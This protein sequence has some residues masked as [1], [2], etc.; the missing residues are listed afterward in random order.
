MVASNGKERVV[1]AADLLF[2]GVRHRRGIRRIAGEGAR[3]VQHRRSA[4]AI[5][6]QSHPWRPLRDGGSAADVILQSQAELVVARPFRGHEIMMELG[7]ADQFGK[8]PI[9]VWAC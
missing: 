6:V 8:C 4:G 1:N 3:G 2:V 9:R 5:P 7:V